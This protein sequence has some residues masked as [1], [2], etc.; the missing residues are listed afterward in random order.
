[1]IDPFEGKD[2]DA[3]AWPLDGMCLECGAAV[4]HYPICP[5]YE[6]SEYDNKYDWELETDQNFDFEVDF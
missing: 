1:M 6:E 5:D 2:Y 3:E 4:S